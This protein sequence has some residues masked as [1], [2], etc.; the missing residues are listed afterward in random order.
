MTLPEMK[1]M[2]ELTVP[3]STTTTDAVFTEINYILQGINDVFQEVERLQ[4][5]TEV[6][7]ASSKTAPAVDQRSLIELVRKHRSIVAAD[8]NLECEEGAPLDTIPDGELVLCME[9]EENANKNIIVRALEGLAE[10]FKKLWRMITGVFSK[11]AE[12]S[13]GEKGVKSRNDKLTE[14]LKGVGDKKPYLNESATSKYEKIFGHLDSITATTI[15]VALTEQTKNAQTLQGFLEATA[16]CLDGLKPIVDGLAE[17]TTLEQVKAALTGFNDTLTERFKGKLTTRLTSELVK[18]HQVVKEGTALDLD[19]SFIVENILTGRGAACFVVYR[20]S[21]SDT[22]TSSFTGKVVMP[23]K[24]HEGQGKG[25]LEVP[26]DWPAV[27]ALVK[28]AVTA[29][30]TLSAVSTSVNSVSEKMTGV[31]SGLQ[32]MLNGLSS[33]LKASEKN[34]QGIVSAFSKIISGVGNIQAG[35]ASAIAFSVDSPGIYLDYA[36]A[37]LTKAPKEDTPEAPVKAAEP[38]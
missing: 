21:P 25:K 27:E 37:L 1:P 38:T 3:A 24:E 17:E 23:L 8:L 30:T 16:N 18:K 15:T 4:A 35:C 14:K 6:L 13:K 34:T 22:K 10:L 26:S 33:K 20:E 7:E 2:S 19:A 9:A 28:Q 12:E 31:I 29:S 32:S 11:K 5:T 36:E